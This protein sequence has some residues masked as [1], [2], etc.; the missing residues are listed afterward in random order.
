MEQQIID[1][2]IATVEAEDRQREHEK[3]GL[4][5]NRPD[6]KRIVEV[7]WH[8]DTERVYDYLTGELIEDDPQWDD[9][10]ITPFQIGSEAYDAHP[11]PEAPKGLEFA[12]TDDLDPEEARKWINENVM[13]L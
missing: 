6:G 8:G 10:W 12:L 1:W 5:G 9:E 13:P 4:K 11:H 2:L 3:E 7:D